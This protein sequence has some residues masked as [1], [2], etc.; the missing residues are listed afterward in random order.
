MIERVEVAETTPPIAWSGPVR[1]PIPR[2][3]VVAPVNDAFVA[4]RLVEVAFVVVPKTVERLVIV[5][6]PRPMSPAEKVL[7]ALNELVV[8]VENAVVKTPV[9][10][11][12]AS[13]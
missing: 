12:Y 3:V 8:V 6:E 1:E 7:S 13:G 5:E 9:D 11:L 2:E 4:K 10:E